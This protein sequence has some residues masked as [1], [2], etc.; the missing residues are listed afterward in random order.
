MSSH[1]AAT[2]LTFLGKLILEGEISCQTGL[3]I[4]AGK[5][6]LEIGG[7]DNPVVKDAFGVPYIPGSSLRGRLRAL[8]EQSLG[9]AVPSELVYLSKRRGQ[10]VRIH[11]S[12]RPDDEVCILFGRNPGRVEKVS[13]E[14]TEATTATPA[15][16]TF[17][18]APLIVDSITP[19]MRE[20]LDDELTEVK[21]ENAVDRITSQANPR[22]L[23]RVPAGARFRFRLILDV[24]CPEDRPLLARVAEALRLLEDDALG[25]GGSRG[26]GRV[27]FSALTLTWR[28]KDYY[29][30]GVSE[31]N[32]LSASDLAALQ[33]LVSAEDF[34]EKLG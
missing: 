7:A 13:G 20:N 3:H 12:D 30:K 22:T 25:G 28:S 1:T 26:N 10:E 23:E 11:H 14:A 5:G 27:T 21:S 4:G 19:Q 24:L 15:R 32:L 16:L 9:L 6:S 34:A 33:G 29:A 31:T 18:D 8:L 17:Y 2:E